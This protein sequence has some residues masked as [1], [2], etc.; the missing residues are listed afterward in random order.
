M[1]EIL[2]GPA[3]RIETERLVLRC[4]E[5]RDAEML[6]AAVDASLEELLPWV[7]WA[8]DEPQTIDAKVELLRQIRGKFDLGQELLYAILDPRESEVIGGCGL[9]PRVGP[10]ARELGYWIATGHAGKG[11]ATEAAAALVR[12]GFEIE[13][14][15]RLEVHCEP[16]NF[17]SIAIPRKLGFRHD[18]TL[19]ARIVRRDGMVA[20]RMIWSMLA[21]EFPESPCARARARAFDAIGREILALPAQAAPRARSAF[22]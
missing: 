9:H 6:K 4:H 18:G 11:L 16:E 14:L 5:P 3:Y 1:S 17:R 19:R 20:D 8:R 10:E 12:V 13:H 15:E 21:A 7:P 22:S 2:H